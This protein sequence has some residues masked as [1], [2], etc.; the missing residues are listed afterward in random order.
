M[1]CKYLGIVST[2]KIGAIQKFWYA[3]I[4]YIEDNERNHH[5]V[6]GGWQK[7]VEDI[8][9]THYQQSRHNQEERK[10][11]QQNIKPVTQQNQELTGL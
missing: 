5:M 10:L 6:P 7:Y 4:V 2:N 9:V 8:Y 1:E 3:L 11:W